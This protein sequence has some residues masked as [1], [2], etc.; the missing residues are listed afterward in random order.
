MGQTP[1]AAN[2]RLFG[3]PACNSSNGETKPQPP[4]YCEPP[5]TF[6]INASCAFNGCDAFLMNNGICESFPGLLCNTLE[7]EYD[8]M[9]CDFPLDPLVEGSFEHYCALETSI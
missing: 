3:N 8:N 5:G 9:D 1:E 7:C 6:G 2:A 4:I